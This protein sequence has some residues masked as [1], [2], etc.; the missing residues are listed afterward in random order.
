MPQRLTEQEYQWG[1]AL[2]AT[3]FNALVQRLIT[4]NTNLP[5]FKLGLI[6][7]QGVILRE[8]KTRDE[9]RALT[10]LDTIALFMKRFMGGRVQ[11]IY[12]MWR[13]RRLDPNYIKSVARGLSL[14]FNKYYDVK[15]IEI[16][17]EKPIDLTGGR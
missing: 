4:K 17:T 14:R 3:V 1:E 2:D 8:P 6:N 12:N 13:K 16:Q 5:A 15:R 11:Q 7:K 10:N 9:Y